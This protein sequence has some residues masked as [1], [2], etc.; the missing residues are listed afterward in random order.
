[1]I[2]R[3]C[4]FIREYEMFQPGN[5]VL[6][7]ISGGADSVCLL[8]VLHRLQEELGIRI[9]CVHVHHGIRGGDADRDAAFVENLCRRLGVPCAVE[10]A[11][12]PGIAA[13]HHMSLEEAGRNARYEIFE[14]RRR[15]GGLD[16]IA[17][18]HHMDDAAETVFMQ[19]LR[20][21]GFRG[22]SGIR[23]VRGNIVRPLLRCRR[24]EIESWLR[25]QGQQWCTDFT[26]LETDY[27]R[28]YIRLEIFPALEA[29]QPR[30]REH[31]L[32]AAEL[33]AEADEEFTGEAEAFLKQYGKM[34]RQGGLALPADDFLHLP[35]SRQRY[36]ARLAVQHESGTLKDLTA[37]HVERILELAVRQTGR[38]IDLPGGIA[39]KKSY[40]KLIF[41]SKTEGAAEKRKF[42]A[43]FTY[44]PF[45]KGEKIPEKSYTKW[46]DYD[47][48]KNGAALRTRHP[49]DFL[50]VLQS[51]GT[52]KLKDYFI[53]EKI[54]RDQRDSR[55]LL[56]DGNH[57]IWVVGGRISEAYKVT[58]S[59][60]RIMQ[61][62][63]E[64]YRDGR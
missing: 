51:G 59:T 50:Q 56:A 47:K 28:N 25:E 52:K 46:F 54:P 6:A 55:L 9:Q 48:I 17:V 15:E 41:F 7:G 34:A 10:A 1:M 33:F 38:R 60:R 43:V 3:I 13:E 58:D 61:V 30:V 45:K 19:L 53:E 36:V 12:V 27:T 40:D 24:S 63:V 23:P 49:G 62:E 5:G 39:V 42:R 26:N 16:K 64:E 11:D 20:G 18:A 32:S 4:S 8:L 31:L 21:S 2:E 37:G 14:R 22:M 44:F 35:V 57:I 29:V